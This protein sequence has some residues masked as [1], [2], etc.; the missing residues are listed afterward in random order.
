MKRG[1][2]ETIKENADMCSGVPEEP[3]KDPVKSEINNLMLYLHD[4][5]YLLC[6]FLLVF[7]LCFRV[8]IVSGDS[9][10]CTLVDGD[11]LLLISSTFYKNPQP[12]DII[13]ANKA[14]LGDSVV[15]RVIATAGQ[16]VDIDFEQG[17]V[18]VDGVALE[19]DYVNTP[20]NTY[21]GVDFPVVVE[22]GC[23]FVLGDNRNISKDSRSP[24][25]GQIDIRE[26]L[27]KAVFLILPGTDHGNSPRE[28]GRI[29]AF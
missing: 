19:E 8:I 24:E 2:Y 4:L 3:K 21:E 18:Y 12:G 28:Y 9:M 17:I 7:L 6:G 10:K 5:V 25:I 13:V 20:T 26:I 11:Y 29:G 22:D 1:K 14:S 27:G 16:V 23:V 15:K